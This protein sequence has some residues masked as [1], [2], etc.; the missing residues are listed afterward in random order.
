MTELKNTMGK[1]PSEFIKITEMLRTQNAS[2]ES[3]W[4]DLYNVLERLKICGKNI[5]T[6][7]HPDNPPKCE[8]E[9]NNKPSAPP[10]ERDGIIGVLDELINARFALINEFD[11]RIHPMFLAELSHLENHI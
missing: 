6:T 1:E 3:R 2:L 8:P 9:Q 7:G 11:N 4:K 5:N 10:L